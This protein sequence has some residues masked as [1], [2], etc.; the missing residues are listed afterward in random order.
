MNG[1]PVKSVPKY[2]YNAGNF[3]QDI[4]VLRTMQCCIDCKENQ[5]QKLKPNRARM[6]N[7]ADNLRC[8]EVV[9]HY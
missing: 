7:F 3:A 8:I 9:C 4:E 1:R 6:L 2:V 5:A